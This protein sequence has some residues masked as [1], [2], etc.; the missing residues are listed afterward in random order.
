MRAKDA[1]VVGR[2]AVGV[3][4]HYCA[5][6]PH[7]AI[8]VFY[9]ATITRECKRLLIKATLSALCGPRECGNYNASDTK[10]AVTPCTFIMRESQ[11][12]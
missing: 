9:S 11:S 6:L 2:V 8:E 1:D 10:V 3:G 5:I 4:A 12:S 7:S